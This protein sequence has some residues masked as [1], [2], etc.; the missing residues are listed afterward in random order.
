[1]RFITNP[2]LVVL[3]VFLVGCLSPEERKA[4]QDNAF[5]ISGNYQTVEDSEEQFQFEITNQNAKHDIFVKLNRDSLTDK[6]KKLLSKLKTEHSLTSDDILN[7]P[8]EMTFGG[9]G[10]SE[11]DLDGGD[12]ISDDFGKTSKFFVCF[13]NAPKYTSNRKEEGK[14]NIELHISYCLSG[15]IKKESKE[16]VEGKLTL[17]ASY[18]YEHTDKE[19]SEEWE[20]QGNVGLN[21]KAKKVTSTSN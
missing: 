2:L 18:R 16:I 1:M 7:P 4:R 8:T 20:D 3:G 12:N 9:S 15:L 14:K 21:Y 17:S 10:S 19:G 13:D 6:E 11:L 5:D